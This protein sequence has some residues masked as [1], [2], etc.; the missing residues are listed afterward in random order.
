MHRIGRSSTSPI[1]SSIFENDRGGSL[2][3]KRVV[4]CGYGS[5]SH[6]VIQANSIPE[7]YEQVSRKMDLMSLLNGRRKLS[8]EEYEQ[9]HQGLILPDQWPVQFLREDSCRD[10]RLSPC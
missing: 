4:L 8:I 3:G 5:G 7:G 6:A 9:I 10:E 2:A 1:R